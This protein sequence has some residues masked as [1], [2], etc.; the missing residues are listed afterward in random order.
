M[1][2]Q[3]A[4]TPRALTP[5]QYQKLADVPTELDWLANIANDKTRRAYKN[6]VTEF[7]V[8]LGLSEP[9]EFRT[10]TRAHVIAWREDLEARE[11]AAPSI[12]RKLSAIKAYDF[13]G[14]CAMT[15]K[16]IINSNVKAIKK[17]I[18]LVGLG[19]AWCLQ[20]HD[21]FSK[22]DG[23]DVNVTRFSFFVGVTSRTSRAGPASRSF[24][25]LIDW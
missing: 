4:L 2:L 24:P 23:T 13:L 12:R 14:K 16:R 17:R 18:E 3:R 5:A 10:V 1:S 21:F 6:D 25:L 19:L 20:N 8:F 15:M 11:L 22:P 9:E 7:P